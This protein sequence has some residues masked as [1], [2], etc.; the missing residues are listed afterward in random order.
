MDDRSSRLWYPFR[1]KLFFFK[2]GLHFPLSPC[3]GPASFREAGDVPLAA[4][5]CFPFDVS[6][7]NCDQLSPNSGRILQRASADEPFDQSIF[8][9]LFPEGA[10]EDFPPSSLTPLPGAG[11]PPSLKRPFDAALK[12]LSPVLFVTSLKSANVRVDNFFL[13]FFPEHFRVW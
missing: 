10:P 12:S 2:K 8:I 5:P 3:A 11:R 4:P 1:A 9:G 13:F 7:M 6:F